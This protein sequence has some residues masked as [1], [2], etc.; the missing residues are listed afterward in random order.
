MKNI[1]KVF[2]TLSATLLFVKISF[3]LPVELSYFSSTVVLNN[4]T[5]EWGTSTETNNELFRVER[6]SGDTIPTPWTDIGFVP[7]HGTTSTPQNYN[8]H[9]TGLADGSYLY[10]L[11]QVDFNGNFEY[12]KLSGVVIINIISVQKINSFVADKFVLHQ[13]Y[14]N[15]FNPVTKIEF[16]LPKS[17]FVKLTIQDVNGK[18][19]QTLVE[20]R[21]TAGSYQAEWKADDFP[22][23]IYFYRLAAGGNTFSRRMMLV[24]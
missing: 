7:G 3:S 13:N 4:V 11:K 21:L 22:S 24:K 2:I 10:R 17:S 15:P 9:D 18:L 23:G 8:F 1:F 12:Y 14:P 20:S 16:D 6:T 19:I 5:L